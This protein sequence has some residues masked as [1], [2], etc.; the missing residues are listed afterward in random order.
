MSTLTKEKAAKLAADINRT[1][2]RG[3]PPEP[4]ATVPA[5][6][7]DRDVEGMWGF[8]SY[9]HFLH[10][11]RQSPSR[12]EGS[13]FI[14]K[15]FSDER[16]VKAA[17]GMGELVG[18]DGGF[19]VPPTFS[20]N[21]FERVYNENNLLAKTD[22]YTSAGNTMVF[23]R[24]AESSRATGSRWGGVRAYW[25]A[26]GSTITASAPTFGQLRLQL[27]KLA[28]LARVTDELIKDTSTT[29]ETYLTRVFALE[30]GFAAN[31]AIFR[32]TGAGQPL[33][34]INAP[35]AV[36]V[37][38]ESGQLAATI[39]TANIAKMWARRFALGP[40]GN[41]VWL[42]NQDV[43]PQLYLMTLGIGTAGVTTFM[44]PGGVSGAPYSTLMGAPIM[45]IEFASTLGTVGDIALVDLSQI[46]SITQGMQSLTSMHVYFTSDE[47]AFRTIFRLDAAPWQASA[48]T[49]L[50]GT[51]TQS[52]IVLLA[53]R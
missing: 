7:R 11:V 48:L 50:N 52:P 46:V 38:A 6:A 29:L 32:G 33:G 37:A 41:Y 36:S 35:C 21:I 28:C 26:E 40:T 4:L 13:A 19:L 44:P 9:S 30:I 1:P 3:T 22:Q 20:S 31:N 15:A 8:K 53:T 14:K 5:T 25:V 42:I 10:E 18:S 23:P 16:V 47:Q 24:N 43:L 27:N 49:P 34:L 39:T 45:E 17:T 12:T 51:N 2:D